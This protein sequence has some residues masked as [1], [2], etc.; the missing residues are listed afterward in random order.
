VHR[1][2]IIYFLIGLLFFTGCANSKLLLRKGQKS[3]ELEPE[4]GGVIFSL[5]VVGQTTFNPYNVTIQEVNQYKAYKRK[6][7]ELIPL[8]DIS[9]NL[10]LFHLKLSKGTY[11]LASFYGW[12]GKYSGNYQYMPCNKIFDVTA[13]E[14]TY[15][16]RVGSNMYF[17]ENS[18]ANDILITDF[19][20]EDIDTFLNRYPLLKD[21]KIGKD[22]LY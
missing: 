6:K 16:G 4:D 10:Y 19:Y 13:G 8:G 1:K 14:I 17:Q 22:L 7:L 15:L 3:I 12:V 18:W 9:G 5:K 21:K 20:K 11:K 2:V